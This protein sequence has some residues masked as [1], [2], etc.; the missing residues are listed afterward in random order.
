MLTPRYLQRIIEATEKKA[1][2]LNDYLVSRIV[3]RIL[4]L[5]EKTGEMNINSS[6]MHD[7][8]KMEY[9]GKLF[10][11]IQDELAR[12][13]PEIQKEVRMAFYDAAGKIN[14]DMYDFTRKVIDIEHEKGELRDIPELPNV[15]DMEKAGIPNSEKDLNLTPKEIRMLEAAYNRTNGEIYNITGTTASVAQQ[16]FIDAC[17]TAYWKTAHGVSPSTAITEAIEELATKGITTVHYGNRKDK[18]EVAIARA[19]RTGINQANGDIKLTRCA[20]LGVGHVVVSSHI[21]ARV[22]SSEDYTNHAHWQGKVYSLDWNNPVLSKYQPTQQEIQENQK[23]YGFLDKTKQFLKRLS[24]KKYKNFI[25]YCGYGKMLGIC[26]IN[27]RHSFDPFWEGVSINTWKPIDPEENKQR[28]ELEQKQRAMERKIRNIKRQKNAFDNAESTDEQVQ[29]AIKDKRREINKLLKQQREEYRKFCRD[30][31]LSTDTYRLQ[32]A[33]VN[34]V[35]NDYIISKPIKIPEGIE[36]IPGMTENIQRE[37]QKGLEDIQREYN[38]ELNVALKEM[39]A[40]QPFTCTYDSTSG[41]IERCININTAFDFED[42]QT[43]VDEGYKQGYFAG[44]NIADYIRHEAAHYMT[45]LNT[46]DPQRFARFAI[47]LEKSYVPGVSGYS[48]D[49]KDGFETIAEA[50][51]K[52]HNGE[53]VPREAEKMVIQLVEKWR[54]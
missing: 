26:G 30:N 19:V 45:G 35:S 34:G 36:K 53:P 23:L 25:S 2:Q 47:A 40:S 50:F 20:E 10:D 28:Y 16:S 48:D 51:V 49:R 32:I 46:T 12:R 42:F 52:I 9:A 18:I 27:C 44:R 17:D 39:D 37:I 5:Y 8:L 3:D 11:E 21:G 43:L 29:K 7:V 14:A 22:T 31:R 38:V 41:K 4:T 13:M 1:E 54:R 6:S 24:G 15:T 33:K